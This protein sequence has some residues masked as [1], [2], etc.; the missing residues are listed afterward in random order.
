MIK[1]FWFCSVNNYGDIL[2]PFLL[3]SFHKKYIFTKRNL[4]NS[5]FVGSIAKWARPNVNVYGSGFISKSDPV[6]KDAI[7]HFVRGPLTR[8]MIIKAGGKCPELYGDLALI[9]PDFIAPSE[10]EYEIGYVP[11]H[12]EYELLPK[13]GVFRVNLDNPDV[14]KIT[15]EITKC[16]RVISSSLHG[17]IVAHAYGIPAAY[18]SL[19]DRLS[20]DGIKFEDYYRSMGLMPILST[21]DNPIFQLPD[22]DKVLVNLEKI[23][24]IMKGID[25]GNSN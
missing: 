11:H 12:V 24:L 10:K 7:Y 13:D 22:P 2:T 23:K 15:K 5:L 4:N 25:D 20:G 6:C 21:I 19:S 17:I 1:A 18:V 16:K 3:D 14:V 8:D 9:L